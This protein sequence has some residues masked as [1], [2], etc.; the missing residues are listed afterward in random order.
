MWLVIFVILL[1]SQY[2]CWPDLNLL[3][4]KDRELKF[5]KN[6]HVYKSEN[7]GQGNFPGTLAR[8]SKNSLVPASEWPGEERKHILRYRSKYFFSP[9]KL[10][11]VELC[12][13]VYSTQ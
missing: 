6:L 4:V 13:T 8:L 5:L 1:I 12:V 2:F 3:Q 9:H 11:T 10:N 7:V